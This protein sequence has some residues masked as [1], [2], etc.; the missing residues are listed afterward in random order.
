MNEE[1]NMKRVLIAD[2]E[3]VNRML[4]REIIE[5]MGNKNIEILEAKDGLEALK[6]IEE[7]IPDLIL[8]D[9][10][11]PGISGYDLC[12]KIKKDEKLKH[13]FIVLLTGFDKDLD[14]NKDIYDIVDKYILKPYNDEEIVDIIEKVYNLNDKHNF[15]GDDLN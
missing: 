1:E 7:N 9:A 3:K 14:E 15:I 4:L 2:D 8:L 13:I 10:L 12:R 6:K 5:D 11:M